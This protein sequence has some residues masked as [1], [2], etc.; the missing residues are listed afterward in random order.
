MNNRGFVTSALLYGILSLFLVLIFGTLFVISNRKLAN[1]RLKESAL[2]DVEDLKTDESCFT[3]DDVCNITGYDE[4]KCDNVVFIDNDN[5]N[6][7]LKGIKDYSF[8]ISDG[9]VYIKSGINISTNA[10]FGS[11]NVTF[12][13]IGFEPEGIDN[14]VWGASNSYI[15]SF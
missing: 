4:E 14:N 8:A 15:K 11:T 12:I 9:Y 3:F 10:F 7:D 2:I 13:T 1:N 6:C 5:I